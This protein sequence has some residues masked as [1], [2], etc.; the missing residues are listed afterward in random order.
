MARLMHYAFMDWRSSKI[1][2]KLPEYPH[3]CHELVSVCTVTL[4]IHV[5]PR[6][7][8]SMRVNEV[9]GFLW[10]DLFIL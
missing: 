3:Q 5:Q 10:K 8:T 9:V 1:D 4:V 7:G 6:N 2:A